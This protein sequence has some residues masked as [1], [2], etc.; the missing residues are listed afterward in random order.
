MSINT[1]RAGPWPVA[2]YSEVIPRTRRRVERDDTSATFSSPASG[3]SRFHSNNWL[4]ALAVGFA[5]N[6]DEGPRSSFFVD[7]ESVSATVHVG[8]GLSLWDIAHS[9]QV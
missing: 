1:E 2:A 9:G 4:C 5:F 6:A 3:K 8:T 7:A